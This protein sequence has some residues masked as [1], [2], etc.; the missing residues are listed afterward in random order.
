MNTS[1]ERPYRP[2]DLNTPLTKAFPFMSMAENLMEE[3][4]FA[5]SGRASLTLAR[6]DELTLVLIVM[7]A[8]TTLAEHP[9]PASAVVIML[10]G[11]IIFTTSGDKITLAEGEGVTFTGDVLHSVHASEDSAFLVVIGGKVSD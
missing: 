7:K 9:A 3:A 5:S 4:E 8:E 10:S 2:V 1:Y 11:E 6:G